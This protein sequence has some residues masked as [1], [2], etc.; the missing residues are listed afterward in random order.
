MSL[1]LKS[2][3]IISFMLILLVP[4][5]IIGSISYQTAKNRLQDQLFLKANENVELINSTINT[6]I[7][8]KM[9][10]ISIF[11]ETINSSLIQGIESPLLRQRLDEYSALHSE[12]KYI[13]VGTTSGLMIM[14][15]N[16][17]LP[18]DYDPRERPWYQGA[19]SHKGETFV[20]EPY[21]DAMTGEIVITISQV[22]SDGSG[23]VALDLSLKNISDITKSIKIGREGY[24][25]IYDKDGRHVIHPTAKPG[26]E[27]TDP[28]I[29]NLYQQD[30]GSFTYDNDHS[31]MTMF[32]TTNKLT[33]W[34]LAGTFNLDEI[35]QTSSPI[36]K[37]TLL[38]LIISTLI[39]GI[40]IYFIILSVSGSLQALIAGSER[41]SKGDLKE[42]I[43]YVSKDEFGKLS[44][45]FNKMID[46]LRS[47]LTR[48][49]DT[50]TQ[51]ASS[52]EQLTASA[53]QTSRASEQIA[54]NTQEV[55]VGADQQVQSV[56]EGAEFVT[57]MLAGIQEIENRSQS[58]SIQASQATEL[59]KGGQSA[60]QLATKQMMSISDTVTGLSD[61]VKGLG[62]RSQEIGKIVNVITEI[63]EQTNLLA[64]NAAIEAARAGEHGRGFAVVADEV[65]KLAEQ[66]A[67]S[68]KQITDLI[69]AIQDETERA[70]KS[71]ETAT[72]EVEQGISVVDQT[73]DSFMNI[74]EAV[75]AV[76]LQINDVS[77]ASQ[78]VSANANRMSEIID[79]IAE[80]TTTTADGAQ[81]ISAASEEQLASMEEITASALALAQM[82]EELQSITLKFKL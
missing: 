54:Q 59:S 66:S 35:A 10:H 22:V 38:V 18:A 29:S 80:I 44:N 36:F 4:S 45:S 2:K 28:W 53:E 43:S 11:S 62:H 52:S 16:E 8:S 79:I 39:G 77:K 25:L 64:L 20:T 82:A 78:R 24:A 5:I 68:A 42:H 37:K 41:I 27:A 40:L 15:P 1:T 9:N 74:H 55:A 23:V 72:S 71:M 70:V 13:Y 81:N 32:F 51:L 3:L 19:M 33:N 60:V 34:K 69:N 31:E 65:R 21:T 61:V 26:S 6:M 30:S 17:K 50:S 49:H 48:I 14:S 56:Q 67:E 12:V 73:G 57:Q 7:E 46:S 75:T 76:T 58:A 63:A 47:I